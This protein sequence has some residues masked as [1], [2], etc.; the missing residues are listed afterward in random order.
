MRAT[1]PAVALARTTFQSKPCHAMAAI[2]NST[3]MVRKSEALPVCGIIGCGL[4]G[5]KRWKSLLPGQELAVACDLDITRAEALAHDA[6][7]GTRATAQFEDLLSDPRVDLVVVATL[8]NTLASIGAAAIR[9]GKAVLL[10]K[11]AATSI[12]EV[13][14]LIALSQQALVP[15]RVGFNH[16]YHPAVRQARELVDSNAIGPLMFIRGRYGH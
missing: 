10:E 9:A 7:A 11:P 16:R 6:G 1:A 5:R 13:D 8:N 12:A 15:V 14:N 2:Q 4:I 3:V